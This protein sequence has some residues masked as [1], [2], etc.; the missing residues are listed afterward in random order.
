MCPGSSSFIR[1]FSLRARCF[2]TARRFLLDEAGMSCGGW[3]ERLSWVF[4][5]ECL[6]DFPSAKA[7]MVVKDFPLTAKL[8]IKALLEFAAASCAFGLISLVRLFV[9]DTCTLGEFFEELALFLVSTKVLFWSSIAS[10]SSSLPSFLAFVEGLDFSHL[11]YC[12]LFF[13]S[14]RCFL[15]FCFCHH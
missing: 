11:A 1:L 6:R 8:N 4:W 15:V 2:L 5:L 9:L 14:C 3:F 12:F 7:C 10:F 13:H